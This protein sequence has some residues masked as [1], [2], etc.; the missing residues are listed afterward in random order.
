[1]IY[2]YGGIVMDIPEEIVAMKM[3]KFEDIEDPKNRHMLEDLR[4]AA[5]IALELFRLNPDLLEEKDFKE[6]LVDAFLIKIILERKKCF[7][8]A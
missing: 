1:M 2:E 3:D 5:I 6:R 4:D 7:Y 8:D